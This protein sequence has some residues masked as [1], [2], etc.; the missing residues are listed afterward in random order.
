MSPPLT[1]ALATTTTQT[2]RLT[3]PHQMTTMTAPSSPVNRSNLCSHQASNCPPLPT[4]AVC[5]RLVMIFPGDFVSQYVSRVTTSLGDLELDALF[6]DHAV[7]WLAIE[8]MFA[9]EWA[10]YRR[11]F[12]AQR[13]LSALQRYNRRKCAHFLRDLAAQLD[14]S[15][16]SAF[17]FP[18]ASRPGSQIIRKGRQRH[19]H[20]RCPPSGCQRPHPGQDE[21]TGCF[22]IFSN[23]LAHRPACWRQL[24]DSSPGAS[25][26]THHCCT[27]RGQFSKLRSIAIL[28]VLNYEHPNSHAGSMEQL[29]QSQRPHLSLVSPDVLANGAHVVAEVYVRDQPFTVNSRPSH[30]GASAWFL[31]CAFLICLQLAGVRLR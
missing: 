19:P 26:I 6:E 18:Q 10:T 22:R 14:L 11:C 17:L 16:H 27:L 20:F 8:E 23:L 2:P 31:S 15:P 24:P 25:P 28:E 12:P 1:V 4:R 29:Q 7:S 13:V 9:L 21:S 30:V 5:F 3:Q